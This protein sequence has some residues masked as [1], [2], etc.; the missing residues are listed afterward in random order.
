MRGV[1][2]FFTDATGIM[3]DRGRFITDSDSTHRRNVVVLG[4]AIADGLFGL[5]DPLGKMIHIDG[6]VFEVIGLIEEREIFFG[7]P[8]ENQFV[9]IPFGTFDK[10]YSDREKEFL[11]FLCLAGSPEEVEAGIQDTRELLRR[12]RHLASDVSDNFAVFGSNQM[13]EIWT[14]ASGG[15]SLLLIGVASLGLLIGGIGVMNIML[16]SVTERTS[17]I[18]L[19]KA[20]GARRRDVLWQFLLE[21]ITLT[22]MGGVAGVLV[23]IGVALL[24]QLVLP[25]L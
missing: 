4:R 5:E 2:H 10:I 8:S 6:Q 24:I 17:E 19:R 13:L 20:V 18:G 21:A 16:V 1:E 9:L 22:L 14:Q 25:S 23:G 15:I 11:Q 3:V 12:R 7:A